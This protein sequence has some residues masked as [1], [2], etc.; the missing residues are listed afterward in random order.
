MFEIRYIVEFEAMESDSEDNRELLI[1]SI[2]NAIRS[3]V[4]CSKIKLSTDR[5]ITYIERTENF[6]EKET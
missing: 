6:F 3:I 4:K 2:A 1:D 5:H